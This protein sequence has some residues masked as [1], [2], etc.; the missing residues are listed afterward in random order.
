MSE[1]EIRERVH[2]LMVNIFELG[3]MELGPEATLYDELGLDSL[4]S[5]D[6]VVALE[7]EF[8]FK[9]V[10]ATDEE[11]IGAMRKLEDVYTFIHYKLDGKA[12]AA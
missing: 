1:H 12:G 2:R 8:G 10:R 5:V 3:T 7:K 4:D 6:L 11:R 9:V